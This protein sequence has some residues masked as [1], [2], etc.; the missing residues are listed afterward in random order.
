MAF[1]EAEVDGIPSLVT[2]AGLLPITGSETVEWFVDWLERTV[3]SQILGAHWRARL[4]VNTANALFGWLKYARA[5]RTRD[6]WLAVFAATLFHLE[7]ATRQ[8]DGTE[9]SAS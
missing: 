8:L 1:E 2:S 7:S 4:H 6:A 5:I 3:P 9:G